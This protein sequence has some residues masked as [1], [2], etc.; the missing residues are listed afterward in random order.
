MPGGCGDS[1]RPQQAKAPPRVERGFLMEKRRVGTA[2]FISGS[3]DA[4]KGSAINGAG[5]HLASFSYARVNFDT[6]RS[7]ESPYIA[8]RYLPRLL[9]RREWRV[10]FCPAILL[11][12][13]WNPRVVKT[14]RSLGI[15]V[16]EVPWPHKLVRYRSTVA[17]SCRS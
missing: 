11:L 17:P 6:R 8:E 13:A 10:S 14:W 2:R 15:E 4:S 12:S 3:T 1:W 5:P 16:D 9:T 7:H